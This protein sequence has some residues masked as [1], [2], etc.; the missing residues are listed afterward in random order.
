MTKVAIYARYSSDNQREASIED[1]IRLCREYAE[2]EGWTVLSCYTD[3]AMS[4]ASLMRPGIQELIAIALSG[5]VDV[6]LSEALDRL[7]RDQE[8][9]AGIYKRMSFADVKIVTLSEGEV[10]NLHVGLKGTMNALFLKDLADKTRRGLRGRVEAGKSGGGNSYGYDVVK[11]L[12]AEGAAVTGEL[13]INKVEAATIR[14]IFCDFADGKS[15]RSLARGLNSEGIPG[16]RGKAWTGSTI[17][18]HSKRGTGILNNELYVGTRVWNRLRY[19]K[20]PETGKRASRLNTPDKW[21]TKDQPELRIVDQALWDRVKARQKAISETFEN[22]Q[23]ENTSSNGLTRTRRRVHLLSG[24]LTCGICGGRYTVVS[25][26]RYGCFN[27]TNRGTCTNSRTIKRQVV[28]E[29]LLSGLKDKLIDPQI[30]R[31]MIREMQAEANRKEREKRLS[32]DHDVKLLAD[33][34]KKI[35][36]IVTI[37]EDGGSRPALLDRLDEL[38]RQKTE[39]KERLKEQPSELPALHPGI[40]DIYRDKVANLMDALNQPKASQVAGEAIRSLIDKV[41]LTPGEQRGE[42]QITLHGELDAILHFMIEGQSAESR[43]SNSEGRLYCI[44]GCGGRI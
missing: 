32:Y 31:D 28:E 23:S 11:K 15:P 18:G 25:Q 19:V 41:I 42:M 30:V 29:R 37:V 39:L 4:G 1:Q 21:I 13:T 33:V 20:N 35:K 22:R 36:G 14:R 26:D 3:E 44:R 16:P 7:S 24:L 8:D 6:V 38:E 34:K 40:A 27:R 5:K 2:R 10:S 43:P 17:R 9:I 12:N